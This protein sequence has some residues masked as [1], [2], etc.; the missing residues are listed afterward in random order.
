MLGRGF[1]SH[2][3][4]N[5]ELSQKNVD[6]Y[7]DRTPPIPHELAITIFAPQYPQ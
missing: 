5:T 7:A 2:C 1:G 3:I 4:A 6:I